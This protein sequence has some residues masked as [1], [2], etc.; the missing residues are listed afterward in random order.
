MGTTGFSSGPHLHW[1]AIVRN[2]RVDA[3]LFTQA[4]TEP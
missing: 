1:E 2:V 4:G 3:R